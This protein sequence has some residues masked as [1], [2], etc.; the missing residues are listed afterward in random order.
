MIT[1]IE[2]TNFMSHAK[3][4]IE[5]AAG[6]TVLVGPNNVGKSAIVAALQILCHNENSTYVM[7]HGERECSVSVR[8]DDEHLVE[9]KRRNSPSYVIDG[10]IFDRLRSGGIPEEL[11]QALR[12]PRVNASNDEEFDIHFGTQKSPIFLLGNSGTVAAR[13]FA[14]SSDAIRLVMVQKRHKE[15]LSEAQREKNRLEGES[16]Q[17]N[18]ELEML[19]PIVDINDR[20]ETIEREYEELLQLAAWLDKAEVQVAVLT[21]HAAR[22]IQFTVQA[23][24][25]SPLIAPPI[26]PPI[27]QL[28]KLIAKLEEDNRNVESTASR[29][30]VYSTI[31]PPPKMATVDVIQTLIVAIE[32]TEVQVNAAN[33]EVAVLSVLSFP[34]VLHDLTPLSRLAENSAR[35][36]NEVASGTEKCRSFVRLTTPPTL[37]DTES[38]GQFIN[39]IETSADELD[40]A[41]VRNENLQ[42]LATP[43]EIEDVEVFRGLLSSMVRTTKQLAYLES[44]LGSLTTLIAPV[45]PTVTSSLETFT[46]Q[47]EEAIRREQGC[48][49]ELTIAEVELATVTNELRS[50]AA[51]SHCRLCGSMLN[52]DQVI[53]RAAAGFGVHEHE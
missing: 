39:R 25:L 35:F 28:E 17:L 43:P 4:V 19:E 37:T 38:L 14:S 3:T 50:Q 30:D 47:L 27:V 11:H 8:T 29:V 36:S 44:Q 24:I 21:E 2:L 32:R 9:W 13:F 15:K 20:L 48:K 22:L 49:N 18:A 10:Q 52:P 42:L 16:R 45:P 7:R 5:P 6:L 41:R 51:Q 12:L 33:L 46:A 23:D 1:R 26:L 34:P 53:A 40:I 31:S